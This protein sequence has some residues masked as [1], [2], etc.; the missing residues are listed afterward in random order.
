MQY[1]LIASSLFT[2]LVLAAPGFEPQVG[3]YDVF[4]PS[5][6][7]YNRPVEDFNI[8]DSVDVNVEVE[9]VIQVDQFFPQEINKQENY[10]NFDK[11]KDQRYYEQSPA[12]YE[13]FDQKKNY[14]DDFYR[15]DKYYKADKAFYD[16]GVNKDDYQKKDDFQKFVA[17]DDRSNFEL[18]FGF[19][20]GAKY[21]KGYGYSKGFDKSFE[22]ADVNDYHK[23]NDEHYNRYPVAEKKNQYYKQDRIVND[24]DKYENT[25]DQKYRSP[26]YKEYNNYKQEDFQDYNKD[27]NQF[28][29][30]DF[31]G[32]NFY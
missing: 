3:N 17:K 20:K 31:I 7:D 19:D 22:S 25:R 14:E 21:D 30:N 9:D 5:Y 4:R 15:A 24:M 1:A 28:G 10:Q 29:G 8:L 6:H 16:G 13:N 12:K 26:G 32:G 11:V 2:G 18:G 27:Y 23:K